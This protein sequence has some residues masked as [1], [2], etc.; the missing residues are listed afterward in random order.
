MGPEH[1]LVLEAEIA[2]ETC[3]VPKSPG[4]SDW[5]HYLEEVEEVEVS[6]ANG[7]QGVVTRSSVRQSF[8]LC[9]S[10]AVQYR[11]QDSLTAG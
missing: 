11:L 4:E 9:P 10:C 6:W 5:Q 3:G 1:L 7:D 8:D 2:C